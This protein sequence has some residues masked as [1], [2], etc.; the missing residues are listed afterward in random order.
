MAGNIVPCLGALTNLPE[1]L[2]SIFSTYMAREIMLMIPSRQGIEY[3]NMNY[4]FP[5]LLV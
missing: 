1:D 5:K 3:K 2:G 4:E